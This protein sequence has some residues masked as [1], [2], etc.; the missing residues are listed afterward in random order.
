[1]KEFIQSIFETSSERIK[2]PFIGSYIIAFLVY[3][4][5]PLF[6]LF[7]SDAEIEDKIVVINHEYCPKEALLWPLIIAL[8]YI[9]VLPY[10]NL[11]FD[12][13]LSFSNTR[14][15]EKKKTYILNNLKH[16]KAEA[17][18]EREIAEERAGTSEISEL[19][20]QIERLTKENEQL[21]KKQ[22]D[23]FERYNKNL[24]ISKKQENE[25]RKRYEELFEQN[26][27]DKVNFEN[28]INNKGYINEFLNS[29][30][31]KEEQKYFVRFYSFM[32]GKLNSIEVEEEFRMK[33]VE[34][35]L[36][37]KAEKEKSEYIVT[38]LGELAY[39]FL[40]GK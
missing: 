33:Y 4:W 28:Y 1:M 16:K 22:N 37:Q 13:V 35:G 11:F 18:F 5:R 29:N 32:N 27:K 31:T 25:I 20:N 40:K 19:K 14:K 12:Y 10:I 30:L 7:F 15:D 6:L 9:L 21:S 26:E 36:L 34:I 8:F 39:N 2:N 3:N 38:N 24:E 23:D 17:K